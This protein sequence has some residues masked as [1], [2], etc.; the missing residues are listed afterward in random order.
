MTASKHMVGM[1]TCCL[2]LP[3]TH[4]QHYALP[5]YAQQPY[6]QPQYTQY[7]TQAQFIQPQQQ[8]AYGAPPG[9]PGQVVQFGGY[10][11]AP[12]R[13][14]GGFLA[15]RLGPPP[16]TQ[17]KSTHLVSS[18]ILTGYKLYVTIKL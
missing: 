9:H 5:Q 3:Q 13:A 10:A 6:A 12:P 4:Q 14:E 1:A 16:P 18:I 7:P 11:P 8:A 15:Q 17:E 2:L